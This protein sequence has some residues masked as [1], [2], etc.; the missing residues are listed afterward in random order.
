MWCDGKYQNVGA[1]SCNSAYTTYLGR[2][3]QRMNETGGVS[4]VSIDGYFSASESGGTFHAT[5]TL[6]DP[7]TLGAVQATFFV[8]ENGLVNGGTTYIKVTRVIKSQAVTT[9]INPGD[10]VTVEI[11]FDVGST[12][13]LENLEGVAVLQQTGTVKTIVQA[14]PLDM[15]T[16]FRVSIPK[17]VV[18]VPEGN[19]TALVHATVQN[20]SLDPDVLN[21][22]VDQLAGW[23]TDMQIAGNP[24][25]VTS[26]SV[27]LDPEQTVDVTVRIQTDAVKRVGTG[28]LITT[29]TNSGRTQLSPWRVFNGSPA[30]LMVD[31]DY[32]GAFEEP[33]L[34]ALTNLGYL[35][36]DWDVHFEHSDISPTATDMGGFDIVIW[37]NGYRQTDLLTA[38]DIA[39]IEQYLDAGGNLYYNSQDF[40][41]TQSGPNTF[42]TDYL[43]LS[44]WVNN[45]KAHTEYG[46]AGDPI[47]DGMVLPLTFIGGEGTNRG[48]R[49]TPGTNS[50]GFFYNEYTPPDCNAV[51]H[52][53]ANG[54]RVVFSTILQNVISTIDPDPNNSQMVMRRILNWL[55]PASTSVGDQV[56]VPT[57]TLS[58]QPNPFFPGTSLSF[59]LGAASPVHLTVV[60]ATGRAVRTLI[61]GSLP[62][63]LHQAV[64]NGM[65]DSGHRVASGIYFARL[66]ST[67]G[68]AS[69]KLVLTR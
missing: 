4:P 6:L 13:N 23:P 30:V 22:S 62:A 17:K 44:A 37:Q 25:W 64:W 69:Q 56:A 26:G 32:N 58:A 67:E 53:M 2:Y 28:N 31:D 20:R 33:Y 40:L 59:S 55:V 54:S 9:L 5:F 3:N 43:G 8:A 49:L 52:V 51:R 50:V 21:L 18:S 12:W 38:G 29:S 41:Y 68:N 42:T 57:R 60:D 46:V 47:S 35:F 45:T 14:A 34:T 39:N 61:D 36:D 7:Y 1:S 66:K 48:D 15:L 11:P 24:Q 10:A 27:T 19:G 63:G 65:D 16:D